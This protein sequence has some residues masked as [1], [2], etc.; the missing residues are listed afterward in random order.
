[1][2]IVVFEGGKTVIIDE[3]LEGW[4]LDTTNEELLFVFKNR[5]F[6]IWPSGSKEWYQDGRLHRDNAPAYIY[7]DGT[8]EW[9]VDDE[10]HRID[11]PA[12]IYAGGGKEGGKEWWV[13]DKRHRID[14]P[15]I[16]RADGPKEWWVDGKQIQEPK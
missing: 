5:D 6:T 1:M 12:V 15:A 13:D 9:W 2:T 8:K 11:G 4:K 3:N 7:A 14:G 10:R 16:I